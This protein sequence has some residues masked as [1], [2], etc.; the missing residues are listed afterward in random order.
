M[1]KLA[2]QLNE[3]NG[4]INAALQVMGDKWTPLLLQ[5]LSS[6]K[7]RFCELET[8]LTGISPRT[9]S[10][11]LDRL[12]EQAIITKC[13]YPEVPPRVEYALTDK[14]VELVPVLQAMADWGAKHPA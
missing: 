12:T 7:K 13:S 9:L 5:N 4:S 8:A 11:R 14:G 6:G 1:D 10:Q 2:P 3:C